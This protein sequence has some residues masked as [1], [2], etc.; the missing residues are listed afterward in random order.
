M[1]TPITVRGA[2]PASPF[3]SDAA[4]RLYAEGRPDYSQFVAELIRAITGIGSPV[5]FAVDV[6]SGTGISTMAIAAMAESVVGVEPSKAMLERATPAENVSYRLGSAEALPIGDRSCDLISVGSAL[7]WF[8]Q[9]RFLA[10]ASRV[11]RPGAWL[12]VHDHWFSGR[13]QGSEDFSEWMQD[14]YI[15]RYP[16]PPRDRSWQPPDDLGEWRHV[17]WE[18]YDHAVLFSVDQLATYLLTQSNLQAV[19]ERRDQDEQELRMW[20]ADGLSAFFADDPH[21]VFMFRGFVACHQ[22]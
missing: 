10:E 15:S 4:A 17:G 14:V 18:S 13:M 1:V 16:S 3:G 8:D 9:D 7:H 12:V 2:M 20:L 11:A 5:S 19:I 22:M 6:G 21:D